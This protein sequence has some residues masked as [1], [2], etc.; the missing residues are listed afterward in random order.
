VRD[1]DGRLTLHVSHRPA[2]GPQE[3]WLPAPDEPF[4]LILR[5]YHPQQ[6]LLDGQYRFPEME[7]VA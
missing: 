1:E 4:Y 5:L 2:P 3:N 7:R 6:R